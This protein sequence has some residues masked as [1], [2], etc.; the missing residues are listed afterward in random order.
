MCSPGGDMKKIVLK[1]FIVST[2]VFALALSLH[3]MFVQN[4]MMKKSI[5]KQ[6]IQNQMIQQS[7]QSQS[8]AQSN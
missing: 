7:L 5:A 3:T 8:V 2:F 1:Q 4:Q 6:E